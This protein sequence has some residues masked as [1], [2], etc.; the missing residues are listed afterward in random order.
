MK[1]R[2]EEVLRWHGKALDDPL[3]TEL[4]DKEFAILGYPRHIDYDPETGEPLA[5]VCRGCVTKIAGWADHDVADQSTIKTDA[6]VVTKIMM[7]QR[8]SRLSSCHQMR[9]LLDDN[10]LYEP[11]V[12]RNCAVK[13]DEPMAQELYK[14]DLIEMVASAMANGKDPDRV[15]GIVRTLAKR[16]VRAW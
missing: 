8:F 14:A 11:L 9:M 16:H 5:I 15:V 7:R 3:L 2:A 10:A 1:P 4:A 6:G 12:C 13:V